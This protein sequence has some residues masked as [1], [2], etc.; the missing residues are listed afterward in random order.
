M[1]NLTTD[2]IC[3]LPELDY[4]L[5]I[6]GDR[7]SPITLVKSTGEISSA[8]SITDKDYL[9]KD[10][11]ESQGDVLLFA[12]QGEYQTNVFRLTQADLDKHFKA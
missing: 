5:N 9:V 7:K 10:Y 12:W 6:R 1:T 11:A 3:S 4:R 2:C 8:T